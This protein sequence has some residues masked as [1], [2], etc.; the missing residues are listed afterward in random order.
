MSLAQEMF[1]IAPATGKANLSAGQLKLLAGKSRWIFRVGEAGFPTVPTICLTRAAWEALQAE[2]GRKDVRL[3]THWVACL[4]RLVGKDGK[5]PVLVVRTS[6]AHHNGGLMPAKLGI[7][8]PA[9]P[10]DSVDPSRPLAKA[11]KNAFD[12]Y[13]YSSWSGPR[14]ED[15]RARQIVLVQ[16]LAPGEIEQFLTRNAVTGALGPAP[17]SGGALPRLPESVEA[18]VALLDSKAGRHMVCTVTVHG[19]Q[20]T[21]LSARPQQATPAAELEAAVDRVTRKIWSAHN[22]VTRVDPSRLALLLHPR[23]KSAEGASKIATGLGVSP[24]AASGVIVFNAE[25]A[26]RLRARGKHCILVVNE[27]GPADIEGMKAATG[28]LT[29]RGGM[30]SHAGVIARITGKPCVAGVRTLS[31]DAAEMVCRI[32]EREFRIGDRLTIDGTDG[33]VYAGTLPLAQPHI[34]GA[35]GTLLGWSDASRT[36]AVRTNAETVDSA[37]TALSFGAEGIGLARSEHMFFSPE[38]MV[39]LRRMILSEDE[40]D[41]S[42]AVNGLV[43]F[44]TGD[45]S[46][47]FS[48]MAGMPVNVRLFDPPLH[49]FLPR[50]DEDIEETANSLGLAVRALRQRLDRIAEV[51]PMLGHRGVRLA[52]T[53]PEILQMQLQALMAGARAASETQTEP[54]LLEVMV[55]FVSTATEVA[56]VRDRA[57]TIAA[58]SGLLRS[59]R[60]KFSLGTMIELPRACLRAGDIA[61]MVDFISFGTNDLTQTTFGISRDDAPT[62]LAAYQRKGV[63]ERDPFVTIDEKGVGELIGIAIQRGREANPKLK[64]GI[65]GEHAG[66]P[67]SLKF[68]AGLGVDYVSCSPYRV[69][70]ARLTLAQASG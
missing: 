57:M 2:R 17:T 8:A 46:A 3:R 28:I 4:Y 20:V 33:S 61:Q 63:Y 54:V 1:A 48:A 49:E 29:A 22:A 18:L 21:F 45:Y 50:S 60:V 23:L 43:D 35:I 70:V 53:Y 24:G 12:S 51:N 16:A 36:I 58:N 39:A 67:A 55:P 42:R 6:A 41:R 27:T 47:L 52:I 7:A 13:G 66:D 34:G 69:P 38:R 37:R 5:P 30:S 62:F 19:G 40:E 64:I 14:A 32:G 15:D 59:E 11:I 68:F 65:C 10:E 31:V 26:A 25:D 56:W 44:Q 9:L